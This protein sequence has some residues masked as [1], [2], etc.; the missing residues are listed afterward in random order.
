MEIKGEV[1]NL[2]VTSGSDEVLSE[3]VGMWDPPA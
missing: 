1:F 3:I 2:C